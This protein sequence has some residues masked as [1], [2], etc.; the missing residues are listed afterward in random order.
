M[1]TRLSLPLLRTVCLLAYVA[2][3][4]VLAINLAHDFHL[5]AF[6]A[7]I[8]LTQAAHDALRF[9]NPTKGHTS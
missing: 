2:A 8:A 7:G 1:H 3:I 9:F 5:T 4:T 6:V